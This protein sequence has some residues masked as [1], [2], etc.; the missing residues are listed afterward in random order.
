MLSEF[1]YRKKRLFRGY[2][3]IACTWG[4]PCMEQL[5]AI[6]DNLIL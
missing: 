5:A 2:C 4:I 1:K 6:F 3:P